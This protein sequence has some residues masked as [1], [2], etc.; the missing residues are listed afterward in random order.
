M[1]WFL[2][3]NGLGHE[4]VNFKTFII[5]AWFQSGSQNALQQLSVNRKLIGM[6]IKFC[7][8]LC[9]V[10]IGFFPNSRKMFLL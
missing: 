8:M 3:D 4:R 10:L 2:Y 6:Q 1:D 5:E 7:W 9:D